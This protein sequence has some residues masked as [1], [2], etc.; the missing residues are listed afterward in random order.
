MIE[1]LDKLITEFEMGDFREEI[2]ANVTPCIEAYTVP[3]P[4]K[5][6]VSKVGGLPHLPAGYEWPFHKERPLEFIAQL[7]CA[8]FDHEYYPDGGLVVF[9]Y[10]NWSGGYSLK[11][12]G[13]IKVDYISADLELVPLEAPAITKKRFYGIFGT[14]NL[15]KVY[16]EARI[17]FR[18]AISLSANPNFGGRL[19]D[20]EDLYF[21]LKYTIAE[22]RFIQIG[23]YPNPQQNENIDEDIARST[24][25][26]KPSDWK[27][28]MEI[29]DDKATDMMWGDAGQL[30][31]F[32]HVEDIK[33]CNFA[34]S[35]MQMQCG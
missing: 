34:D 17:H 1:A 14:Y 4:V 9:F 16:K 25:R 12:E 18:D 15:P 5:T 27:L 30:Y 2:H 26:G 7:N 28:I 8:E 13:F 23:G 10:D 21:E 20:L 31:F 3:D 22:N 35:W 33:K 6:G 29:Y 11:D 19:K 32:T 24:G